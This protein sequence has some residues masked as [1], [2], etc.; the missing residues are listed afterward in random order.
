MAFIGTVLTVL[1]LLSQCVTL[2]I[3]SHFAGIAIP[4]LLILVYWIQSI[5]LP[6]SYQLRLLDLE[7]KAPIVSLFV[8]SIEGLAT[9]RTFG[10]MEKTQ[11]QSRKHIVASQAPFYLLATAQI[12]LALVLDL[13]TAALA[14]IIISISVHT[15]DPSSGLAL[16]SIV[17]LGTST[18]VLIAQWTELETSLG[19]MRRINDFSHNTP[20]EIASY[21]SLRP[22]KDWPSK[23]EVNFCDVSLSHRLVVQHC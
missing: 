15:R 19:A 14:I 18:K 8:R 7:A 11:M 4:V 5:Y 13:V 9:I 22:P 17:G 10:W 12:M 20:R 16:F 1:L 21:R 6:T 2:I 23:G 3:G